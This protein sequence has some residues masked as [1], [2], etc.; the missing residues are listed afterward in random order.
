M[1]AAGE[2]WESYTA[3]D[4]DAWIAEA[5]TAGAIVTWDGAC[6]RIE[7]EFA[8]YVPPWVCS[9]LYQAREHFQAVLRARD[10]ERGTAA[11]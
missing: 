8:G 5:R 1:S 11:A 4:V 9:D 6:L 3:A 10:E 7:A 2:W